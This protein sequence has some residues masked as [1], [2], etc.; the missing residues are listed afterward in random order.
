MA[1]ATMVE[2][3]VALA[4]SDKVALPE[5]SP[6]KVMTGSLSMTVAEAI[7][8][9]S[10]SKLEPSISTA[11]AVSLPVRVKAATLVGSRVPPKLCVPAPALIFPL[12]FSL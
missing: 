3:R 8:P 9:P 4:R 11:P 12:T 7:F 2:V 5:R 10:I 1:L 6:P